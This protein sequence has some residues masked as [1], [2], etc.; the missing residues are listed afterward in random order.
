M[1]DRLIFLCLATLT[2]VLCVRNTTTGDSL[3]YSNIDINRS[4]P[5]LI[6]NVRIRNAA[7]SAF[8]A[9][10]KNATHVFNCKHTL[11]LHTSVPWLL[12]TGYGSYVSTT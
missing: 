11:T 8:N 7:Y 4:R 6:A 1:Y 12:N 9:T 10:D 3:T 2:V 5:H